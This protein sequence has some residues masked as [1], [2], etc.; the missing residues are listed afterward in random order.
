M[1]HNEWNNKDD[2]KHS[3]YDNLKFDFWFL[4]SIEYVDGLPN[5]SA[6]KKPV[7]DWKEPQIQSSLKSHPSWVTLYFRA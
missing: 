7:L 4:R 2:S 6:Q 5:D 1:T 3:K